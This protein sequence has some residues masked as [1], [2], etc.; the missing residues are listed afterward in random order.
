VNE[1]LLLSHLNKYKHTSYG[2][3]YNLALI[4]S[5]E[6]FRTTHEHDESY[7][8]R[9]YNGETNVMFPNKVRMI[10]SSHKMIPVPKAQNAVYSLPRV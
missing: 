5:R 2:E 10:G 9:I 6:E 8:H 4:T 7:I 1:K 3:E